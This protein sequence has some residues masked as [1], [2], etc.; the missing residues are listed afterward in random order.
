MHR[1]NNPD[2]SRSRRRAQSLARRV[3]TFDLDHRESPIAL[4]DRAVIIVALLLLLLLL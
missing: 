4:L 3:I 1:R 2:R